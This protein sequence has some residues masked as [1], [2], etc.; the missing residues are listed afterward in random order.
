MKKGLKIALLSVLGLVIVT[1]VYLWLQFGSLV[2]GAMSCEKL[3]D[4][5]YYMEYKGDDGFKELM[6]RGGC[7]DISVLASYVMEFL[8]KGHFKPD[9]IN[10]PIKPVGCSTL[11]VK[12]PEDGVMMARN[13]DY[14]YGTALIMHTIP[15]EG[16]ESI[17]TFSTDFFGFGENYKPE[18]FKNQYMALTGLFLALDGLNEKGFAIAVLDAGDKVVT[19]QDTSKPDLTTTTAVQYL[20]KNAANIDEALALL[21]ASDMNSDPGSAYHFSMADATGRSVTVEYVDNKMVVT[22]SPFVTN[23]YLCEEKFQVGLHESDHRHEKLMEQYNAAGG[24][25]NADQL[26]ETIASVTQLP[27]KGAIVGGTLWTMVMDLSHPSVTYYSLRH[28]DKPFHFELGR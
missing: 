25:M 22:E 18:G 17:T 10:V 26:T 23:H 1:E 3:D 20:L 2:Q 24:V 13:F 15:D 8:S 12:T 5:M 6:A 27:E 4:G 21:K 28:F 7:N 9:S 11:T 14:P 16:Y 19:R